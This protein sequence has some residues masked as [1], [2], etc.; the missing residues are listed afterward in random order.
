MGKIQKA[1]NRAAVEIETIKGIP[2]HGAVQ[3]I[4]LALQFEDGFS[5]IHFPGN[6]YA[7]EK[8]I[9]TILQQG[10]IKSQPYLTKND[11]PYLAKEIS[12]YMQNPVESKNVIIDIANP[13]IKQNRKI[14]FSHKRALGDEIMFSAGIR[15]F[16]L[17]FPDIRIN[18]IGHHPAIW[19]NNPYIDQTINQDDPNV[20]FY[21]VGY[22]AINSANNT[23]IHFS[24]MFL[25]DMIA[26]ADLEF[27]LP[28]SLGEFCA[29]FGNGEV[30]D[31][32]L[33]HPHKSTEAREPYISLVEKY[34]GFSNEFAR[35]RGDL[36]L[37]EEEKNIH[38]VRE[39]Y[40]VE[41]Y[42]LIAPG[43]KRDAT[44]KIWDWR[45]FKDVVNHFKG[46]IQFVMI[47][48][49]D[50]LVEPI[51]GVID[52]VDKFNDDLRGLFSL[53]YNAQGCVSGL[54]ALMHL[55]AALPEKNMNGDVIRTKPCVTLC[56][57]REP[58]GWTWYTHHQILHSNATMDCCATGGCWKARTIPMQKDPKHNKSLCSHTVKTQGRTIQQCMENITAQDVI[59]AIE[60]YFEGN[61]YTYLS[62]TT[63]P[64]IIST[65]IKSTPSKADPARFDKD[66]IK[67]IPLGKNIGRE[68]NLLGNLNTKGGGEQSLV[69]IAKLLK[70]NG[71]KVNLFPWGS[72]HDDFKDIEK[73]PVSFSSDTEAWGDEMAEKMTPGLPLLFYAN[74]CVWDFPKFA[75]E[76]VEKSSMLIVGINFMLGG[77]KKCDWLSR[78]GKLRAV[79]F[80]NTEKR[81]EWQAQA[82]GYPD[83][84]LIVM[85]GAIDLDKFYEVCPSQRKDK[86]PMIVLK[87]CLD[88]N[89]K[90]V[91]EQSKNGGSKCHIW[92]HHFPKELDTK[93]YSRLLK[94]I[95]NVN[96][97]FMKAPKELSEHFKNEKRMKF[98]DW[99]EIPVTEFLARGHVY[100]YRTSN[101]WRD[102]YPRVMAEALAAGL[103]VIGEP[104]DGPRDR[105]KHGDNGYLATHYDEYELHLRTLYRK[106][107]FRHAMG[108]HAKDWARANLH[109]RRWV[110]EINRL[111]GVS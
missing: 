41:K 57:G 92:Q 85:Y 48:K 105:I 88:D 9:Q 12:R 5:H 82:I 54:S 106:E 65:D 80:Q 109:P 91:T 83:T 61:L 77:F 29:A 81:E 52:L 74:D 37:T 64:D 11:V 24:T 107:K 84:E 47:G 96:F 51:D 33:G 72:V 23:S 78:S 20:E 13:S 7:K 21:K 90:Y 10:K 67:D 28:L 35:M 103:P 15:D 66:L 2:A 3:E 60:K 95:K 4:L 26:V 58:T 8:L 100:L 18:V 42:W 39:I 6:P 108:M 27:R 59:R 69:M 32:C 101:H 19:D 73:M 76:V 34:K 89:R 94:D 110:H 53:V 36:H 55:A 43:G 104:R 79:I 93:F 102:N 45:K 49:S 99:N 31:P 30:G 40:G 17:L 16:K 86:E 71:W 70:E 68:I 50:L 44:T 22:K 87:H 46:K 111:T 56:G 63:T 1:I 38:L 98:W 25:L 62:T 75:E 14:I 97:E